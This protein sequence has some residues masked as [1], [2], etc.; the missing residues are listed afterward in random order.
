MRNCLQSSGMQGSTFLG[1]RVQSGCSC[2]DWEEPHPHRRTRLP[3]PNVHGIYGHE[4]CLA[5]Q[6]R[7]W[8]W[9]PYYY[10]FIVNQLTC[11]YSTLQ[12]AVQFIIVVNELW[13]RPSFTLSCIF[14]Y[15][16][17]LPLSL[18]V[19]ILRHVILCHCI[20]VFGQDDK[21]HLTEFGCL[22]SISVRY[23][24]AGSHRTTWTCMMTRAVGT[25]AH[26]PARPKRWLRSCV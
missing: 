10:L 11:L 17:Y 12:A 26:H 15:C 22:T 16:E 24:H 5:C 2:A 21:M 6:S 13:V 4:S 7:H 18:A 9:S 23:T 25:A 8:H 14:N 3:I 19:C 1:L 20:P